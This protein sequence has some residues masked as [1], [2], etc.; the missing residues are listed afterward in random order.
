MGIPYEHATSGDKAQKEI[1]RLLAQFGCS[2]VGFMEDI[3]GR[4]ITLVFEHRGRTVSMAAN[5]NGWA[6]IWLNENPWHTDRKTNEIE[7]HERAIRQGLIAVNSMLRDWVKGQLAAVESGMF[8]FETAFMPFVQ[9][10][11]GR[12]LIDHIHEQK[13]LPAPQ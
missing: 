1:K 13:L 12:R 4:S 6:K 3:K 10:P 5:A 11:D 7:W 2:K 9:L 8:D